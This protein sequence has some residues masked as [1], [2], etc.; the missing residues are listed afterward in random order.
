MKKYRILKEYGYQKLADL[1]LM[2]AVEPAL[3]EAELEEKAACR[4]KWE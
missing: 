3:F 2:E 4:W 1:G